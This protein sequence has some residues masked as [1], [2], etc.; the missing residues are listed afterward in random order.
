MQSERTLPTTSTRNPN[1]EH[2]ELCQ[3]KKRG[4]QAVKLRPKAPKVT[5][6]I[7]STTTLKSQQI[8]LELD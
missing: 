1:G 2:T 5:N 4:G 8:G 7:A 3:T 6:L